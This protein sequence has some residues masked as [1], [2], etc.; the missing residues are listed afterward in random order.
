VKIKFEQLPAYAQHSLN[1]LS[2]NP[3]KRTVQGLRCE[4]VQSS[5]FD[6]G[7]F[8]RALVIAVER[9]AKEFAALDFEDVKKLLDGT[10]LVDALWWF[11]ENSNGDEPWRS[12]AFFYLRGRV[13]SYQ[14]SFN[15]KFPKEL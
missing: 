10:E 5:L 9:Y 8:K 13:R 3:E 12:E 6:E 14:K 4:M 11:T 1:A 7:D 15:R 2:T